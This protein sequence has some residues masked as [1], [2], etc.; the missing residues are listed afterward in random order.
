MKIIISACG[1]MPQASLIEDFQSYGVEVIGIDCNPLSVGF[2]FCDKYY[3]VPK[4]TD[5]KFIPMLLSICEEERPD[6][7]IISPDEELKVISFHRAYFKAIGVKLL[8]PGRESI[9]FCL[10]KWLT[11]NFFKEYNI[12]T[13]KTIL[14]TN[15]YWSTFPTILKPREGRGGS[16]IIKI[17][18][19]ETCNDI[20]NENLYNYIVQKFIEGIEYSVDVLCDWNSNPIS[21]VIRERIGIE[22]GISTKGKIVFD[23]EIEKYVKKIVKKLKFIGMGCIQCI[24]GKEGIKFTEINIRFGGGSVLSRRADPTIITNYLRLIKGEK[25]LKVSKPKQLTMLRYYSEVI[26]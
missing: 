15:T 13:P 9:A 20:F 7:I 12:P 24:R 8:I 5:N 21:I 1:S 22:S 17:L 4:A 6:C 26:K 16:G 14:Y 3:V 10:D 2:D 23:K 11:Y 18:T 25:L 19:K